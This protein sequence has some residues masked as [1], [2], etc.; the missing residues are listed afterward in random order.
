MIGTII[1]TIINKSIFQLN[2]YE[3]FILGIY[4]SIKFIINNLTRYFMHKYVKYS[5][6]LN[7]LEKLLLK[8][9]F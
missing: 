5:N 9:Q 2:Y 6:I 4:L 3:L 7:I 8:N 1:R